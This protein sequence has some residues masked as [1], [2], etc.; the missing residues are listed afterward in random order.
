MQLGKDGCFGAGD[1]SSVS[2]F[3]GWFAFPIKNM[4]NSGGVA[5]KENT[6]ITGVYFY[7]CL[8]A[9]NMVGKYVYIDNVTLV[10]D[11]TAY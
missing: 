5:I 4:P 1:N 2:G 3:K 10:K 9:E 6:V 7:M 11:Y 8:S